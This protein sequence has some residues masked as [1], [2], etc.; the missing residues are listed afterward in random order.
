MSGYKLNERPIAFN[1][2]DRR[3]EVMDIV[4]RW[5][6]EGTSYF[7]V[8][9]DDDN[10]YLLKYDGWEDCWELVFY[11]NPN[12]LNSLPESQLGSGFFPRSPQDTPNSRR[13]TCLH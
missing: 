1:L 13:F 9:A 6:G 4:D 2:I 3:Y 7:K 11:Q 5:Y 8:R 10:I 12:K